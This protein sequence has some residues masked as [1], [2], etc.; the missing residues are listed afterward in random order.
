MC[1]RNLFPRVFFLQESSW[2]TEVRYPPTLSPASAAFCVSFESDMT[3]TNSTNIQAQISCCSLQSCKFSFGG[4]RPWISF[5]FIP[6]P[7]RL[8]WM[9]C[10]PHSLFQV[11]TWERANRKYL[12]PNQKK[13]KVSGQT[14]YQNILFKVDQSDYLL[15]VRPVGKRFKLPVGARAT[16]DACYS[17]LVSCGV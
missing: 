10:C 16:L 12:R 2:R 9:E 6:T 7:Q 13:L 15:P 4:S 17:S 8:W 3:W 5:Y 11:Y 14:I 1:Y